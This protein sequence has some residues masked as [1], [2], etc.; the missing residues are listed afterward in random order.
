V[1]A[2]WLNDIPSSLLFQEKTEGLRQWLAS[3]GRTLTLVELDT[4]RRNR[5]K[6]N[7][8]METRTK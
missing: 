7:R 8:P 2:D 3:R 6:A 1:S 5:G 4:E